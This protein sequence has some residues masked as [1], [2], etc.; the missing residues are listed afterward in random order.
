MESAVISISVLSESHLLRRGQAFE[1]DSVATGATSEIQTVAPV[2]PLDAMH[3]WFDLKG[4]VESAFVRVAE[5]LTVVLDAMGTERP[6]IMGRRF[7]LVHDGGRMKVIDSDLDAASVEWIENR[8]NVDKEL[9]RA[10]GLF[11]KQVVRTYGANHDREGGDRSIHR[12]SHVINLRQTVEYN[13]LSETVD[14]AVRFRSLLNDVRRLDL[15][16]G[17]DESSR[18]LVCGDLV[19]DYL[20]GDICTYGLDANGN[21]TTVKTRGSVRLFD[22]WG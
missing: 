9:G 16:F 15:P 8:V 14:D 3:Q 18:F 6:D 21:V 10:A 20:V 12:G 17:V 7:D 13:D 2:D 4:A 1:G 5:R 19:Q 22:L 11:N